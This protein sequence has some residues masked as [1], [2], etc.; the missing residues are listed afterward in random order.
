MQI[1]I[2]R[3]REEK[4]LPSFDRGAATDLVPLNVC[5]LH[6]CSLDFGNLGPGSSALFGNKVD[7]GDHQEVVSQQNFF[8][9]G[10]KNL[11]KA[12]RDAS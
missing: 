8:F 1:N 11:L 12:L 10:I 9:L 2:E 6:W 3:A 4:L 7:A 5:G